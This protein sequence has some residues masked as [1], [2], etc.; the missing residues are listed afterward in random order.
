MP[1]YRKLHTCTLESLDLAKMPDDFTRLTWL[2]LPLIMSRDGTTLDH[3]HFLRS[4]L[5]ALRPDVTLESMSSAID[6]FKEHGL[7]RGYRVNGCDYL[8]MPSWGEQQG[9]SDKEA[10]STFPPPPQLG[11]DSGG[12][13]ELPDSHAGVA[14]DLPQSDSASSPDPLSSNSRPVYCSVEQSSVAADAV[15]ATPE[16]LQ[17]HSAAAAGEAFSAWQSARG[18]A[19]NELDAQVISDLVDEFTAEWVT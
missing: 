14:P 5:Y 1:K 11:T 15:V 7:L 4:R 19:V 2:L 8:W 3:A 10:P 16:Q 17:S 18:G 6:W 9:R 13:P 12:A